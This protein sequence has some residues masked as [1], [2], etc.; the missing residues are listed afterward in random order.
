MGDLDVPGRSDGRD[1]AVP[2]RAGVPA[3]PSIGS[4]EQIVDVPHPLVD[5]IS[6]TI[7]WQFRPRAKGGSAFMI[8]RRSALGSLK[9]VEGFSLTEEGWASAWRSL[10]TRN[11]AAVLPVLTALKARE[12]DPAKLRA[13]EAEIVRASRAQ[14]AGVRGHGRAQM[15][16]Y[17]GR[18]RRVHSGWRGWRAVPGKNL[19]IFDDVVVEIKAAVLDGA[20]GWVPGSG[21]GS[22][23]FRWKEIGGLADAEL[24]KHRWTLEA[25]ADTHLIN[26]ILANSSIKSATVSAG[27]IAVLR[28]LTLQTDEGT[29]VIY[30]EADPNPDSKIV[31]VLKQAFGERFKVS[32]WYMR[33]QGAMTAYRE[34]KRLAAAGA[35]RADD[36]RRAAIADQIR[37]G[38]D[39][40]ARE[41]STRLAAA[42]DRARQAHDRLTEAIAAHAAEIERIRRE[43]EERIAA[44]EAE[45]DD[46]VRAAE[47]AAAETARVREDAAREREELRELLEDRASTLAEARDAQRRRAE[48]AEAELGAAR[49]DV[50]QQRLKTGTADTPAVPRRRPGQAPET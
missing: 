27:P 5:G 28:R 47:A 50:A 46:D 2:E 21:P 43:A 18:I 13:L 14:I 49:A 20:V 34:R 25:L 29:R 39:D 6:P 8:I 37:A 16:I 33:G 40:A 24:D 26:W 10:I 41:M 45:R 23:T 19:V 3:R 35:G 15:S 32:G 48:R 38:A 12:I 4:S 44:A 11:P 9:V 30:W 22:G 42:E 7:G 1:A 31:P 17:L 36:E